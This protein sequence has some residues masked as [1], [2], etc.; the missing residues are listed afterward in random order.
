M[1]PRALEAS[2]QIQLSNSHE[3]APPHS[4]G[5]DASES[6]EKYVLSR[7]KRAQGMPGVELHPQPRGQKRVG[8]PQAKSPQEQA[9]HRHSL[10]N[11]V[12]GCFALSPEERAC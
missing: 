11:G 1:A 3:D 2:H 12:N 9:E 5:A 6:C 4:R 10:R 7:S 8:G